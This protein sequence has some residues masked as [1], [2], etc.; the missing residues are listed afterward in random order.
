MN[1]PQLLFCGVGWSLGRFS[2]WLSLPLLAAFGAFSHNESQVRN[3]CATIVVVDRIIPRQGVLYCPPTNQPTTHPSAHTDRQRS[4][5][6]SKSIAMNGFP[7]SMESMGLGRL[8][9]DWVFEWSNASSGQH[10][11]TRA[12]KALKQAY[13]HQINLPTTLCS[14]TI[15]RIHNAKLWYNNNH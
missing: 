9:P 7:E 3:K 6:V 14:L 8:A 5:L 1:E 15:S 10:R 4:A 12:L 13:K 11:N 2:R